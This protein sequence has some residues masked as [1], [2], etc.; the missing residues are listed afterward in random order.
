MQPQSDLVLQEQGI[1][2][3]IVR[4]EHQRFPDLKYIAIEL[5]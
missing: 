5:T 4:G 1:M 2:L 3:C